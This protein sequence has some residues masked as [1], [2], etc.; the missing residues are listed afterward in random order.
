MTTRMTPAWV[1]AALLLLGACAASLLV[2]ARPIPP[3]QVW[4]ALTEYTGTSND[5]VILHSRLPRTIAGLVVGVAFGVSGALIQ[6]FT[7]NPL[8]DP[9]ILGVN[10]GAAFAVTLGVAL[11]SATS[12]AVYVWFALL[13]AVAA[14]ATVYLIGSSG[15]GRADP[16]TIT[17][18]GV[19]LAAVLTGI[20]TAITLTNKQAF[21]EMRYWGAG[22]L[23]NRGFDV[24]TVATPLVV[25]GL[26][27]AVVIARHLDNIALGDEAAASL[28]TRVATTRNAAIIAVT[29]L[30]GAGTAIAGP[31]GFLGLMVPHVVRWIVGPN[32]VK[33]ITLTIVAAPLLLLVSDVIGRVVVSGELQVGIVTAFIGAPALIYLARKPQ[34]AGL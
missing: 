13:G 24:L 19:A 31:I 9:G 14:T 15:S 11:F 26:V 8:A 29:L 20:T 1:L 21:D 16:L 27:V 7:R 3:D 17:L 18:A 5:V 30:C 33:V 32:N 25:A 28:G 23:V 22:S 6:A 12:P 34:A 4:A 10:A 2:G